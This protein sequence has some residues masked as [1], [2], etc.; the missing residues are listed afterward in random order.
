MR[1][2]QNLI[3]LAPNLQTVYFDG[4]YFYSPIENVSF[5]YIQL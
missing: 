2:V 1:A 3:K 4:G 5:L